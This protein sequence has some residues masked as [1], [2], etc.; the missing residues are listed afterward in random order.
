MKSMSLCWSVDG[1]AYVAES[2]VVRR[3]VESIAESGAKSTSTACLGGREAIDTFMNRAKCQ[4]S[5]KSRAATATNRYLLGEQ[6][7]CMVIRRLL[8]VTM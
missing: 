7:F 8:A 5:N 4:T 2:G 6:P 3:R 1:R